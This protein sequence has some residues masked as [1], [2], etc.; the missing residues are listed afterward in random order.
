[1]RLHDA[2]LGAL[3]LGFAGWVWWLTTFFPAFPGQDYGPN[4]FPRILAAG[5][6]LCALVLVARGLRRR[7]PL[8]AWEA[9]AREPARVV[10][11]L[12]LP[13]A[14][15]AYIWLSGPLGFLPTAFAILAGL[16][17]WYGARAAVALPVAAGLALAVHWFFAGLMRV[18]LP[19]GVLDAWL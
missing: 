15:L 16:S 11:V 19:R 8:L 18:P 13:A 17:L 9:W 7:G 2:A 10:S 5:I 12:A 6:G 3:L 14:V 1:M 4:L